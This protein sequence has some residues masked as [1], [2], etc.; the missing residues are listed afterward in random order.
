MMLG[1]F[2]YFFKPGLQEEWDSPETEC[3]FC[4]FTHLGPPSQQPWLD[5]HWV[6]ILNK[7]EPLSQTISSKRQMF[8]ECDW[9]LSWGPW[10]PELPPHQ[11]QPLGCPPWVVRLLGGA[12]SR[13]VPT[14]GSLRTHLD[15]NTL[16]VSHGLT[17]V[18]K[19]LLGG[20][21]TPADKWYVMLQ[22]CKTYEASVLK[23]N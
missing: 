2:V 3:K 12:V 18:L 6:E 15:P 22:P 23:N 1:G 19:F 4:T 16:N 13:C 8:V 20:D 21:F 10:K 7:E 17:I 11:V 14:L 5:P 9:Q